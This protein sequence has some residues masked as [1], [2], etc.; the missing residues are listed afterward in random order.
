MAERRL[1]VVCAAVLLALLS[2]AFCAAAEVDVDSLKAR[3]RDEQNNAAQR[4]QS[5]QRLTD[6][7]RRVNAG[8]AAA[9][10]RIL[11]LERGIAEQQN[12]LEELAKS[13]AG[14]KAEYEALLAD[15]T[16][17]EKAQAELLG[18]LWETTGKRIS[19]GGREMSDWDVADREYIWSKELYG[20]L[21]EYRTTLDDRE[22][23]LAEVLGRRRKISETVE[24]SLVQVAGEKENLLK[25]RLS[26]SR[27][28]EDVRDRKKDTE[29]E[30]RDILK[31]VGSLN[32]QLEKAGQGKI[33]NMKGRLP[34]P[35]PGTV[36]LSYA[37]GADPPRRGLGFAASDGQRV[38]AVAAGKVVHNDILRGFGTVLI[39]QHGN[40][41]YSLYA[42]LGNS[43]LAV[44]SNVA[45]GAA[46]G[47]VGWYP[48]IS[49]PGLYFELRF[50][51]KAINP[52]PWFGS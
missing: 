12:R 40:N 26:Y 2:A 52:L 42:F 45:A 14:A 31:L 3:L 24:Q 46:I 23:R 43:P 51:Q 34:R 41:Y 30:L 5:L 28:L 19:V 39:L 49:G 20:R 11:E 16:R 36:R 7:E 48:A 6:E 38:M 13:D 27:K 22:A 8:L 15:I 4:R 32:L 1:L 50:K 47:T 37:P 44:G 17:T 25:E 9:E 29:E 21:E 18:L 33:E 35:V 10:R